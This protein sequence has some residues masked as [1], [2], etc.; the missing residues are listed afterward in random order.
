M[1]LYLNF[2]V[3][4][5]RRCHHFSAECYEDRRCF[6]DESSS[7]LMHACADIY[8]FNLKQKTQSRCLYVILYINIPQ[9][10]P[11]S[12]QCEKIDVPV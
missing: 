4:V 5:N 6:E 10:H 8:D 7:P 2:V 9:F 12:R 3:F 11:A 1:A